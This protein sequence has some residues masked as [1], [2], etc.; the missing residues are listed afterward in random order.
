MW[1]TNK[2]AT[3][4]DIVARMP[5]AMKVFSDFGIDYCCGGRRLLHDVINEQDIDKEELFAKLKKV[6]EDQLNSYHQPVN[7]IEM[8]PSGLAEHIED[9]HHGY[10]RLA[11]P[12][13]STLLGNV[14]RAHGNNHKELFEVYSLFGTLKTEL[15][16]HLLKE[17][18]NLFPIIEDKNKVDE[19]KRLTKEIIAEHEH[20]GEILSK[21]R[22]ITSDYTPPKDA[23]A[24]YIKA[25]EMLLEL[26]NDLH[27]HIHLENNILL[28]EYIE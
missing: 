3:I 26:E 24:S 20:A 28:K 6:E 13:I 5:N 19:I 1:Y 11:L 12:E 18:L 8:K 21:L 2:E 15:E 27:H 23:C 17:E 14:L 16:M 7:Y 25:Y 22:N 9:K 10:L 4:G